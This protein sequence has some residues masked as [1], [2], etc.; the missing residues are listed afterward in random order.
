[1][2]IFIT[3]ASGLVGKR[4]LPA[5]T[6]RGDSVVA[7]SRN[8]KPNSTNV[9]W[10]VGDPTVAGPWLER[11]AECDA[12]VHLAGE[13]IMGK[14][15][16]DDFLKRVRDSRVESTR[17]IAER[18]VKGSNVKVFV[19][20]SAVGYYGANP[21]DAVLTEDSPAGPPGDVMADICRAW[22]AAAEPAKAAGVR[23]CHPRTGIV[24][25]RD[26]G[27]LPQM[28]LPFKLF[29]GGRIGSGKQYVAWIH[30]ADMVGLLLFALDNAN[31]HGPFNATAPVPVRNEEFS[32]ELAQ[33]LH[34]PN[35]LPAPR[36]MLRIVVGK[37]AEIIF[38]GQNAL[39]RKT[40]E[41]GYRF[42]YMNVAAA[43]D[44]LYRA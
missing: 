13:P 28:T 9:E 21:G 16:S 10:L 40:Q 37:A 19:S 22:E 2:K 12:V 35:W 32:R 18:L 44:E 3:G 25:D 8:A 14:R 26:G 29:G 34:R 39:P 43:L 6:A 20:G 27:A 11:M 5:L 36:F 31:L 33:V 4:L 17:I 23:V 24:L 30:H 7:L 1:M 38:G 15:W 42:K 41:L